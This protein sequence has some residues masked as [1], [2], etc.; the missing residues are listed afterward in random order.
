MMHTLK[1][2]SSASTFPV[3]SIRKR[4]FTLIELLVVIAIIAIL[5]G[6]LLPALSKA[7]L[8]AQA[9]QCLNSTKQLTLSWRMYG[10]DCQEKLPYAFG[11]GAQEPY[12]WISGIRLDLTSASY[13]WD[14]DITIK[15]S[16]LWT[17]CGQNLKIFQ[18]AADKIRVRNASGDMVQRVRSM[19]M[20]TFVGGNGDD[21]AAG[22]DPAG[23]WQRG[24]T[25]G[26]PFR[27][28]TKSTQMQNAAMTIVL[29][30]ERP[31]LL[32]D[33][34]FAINM[35]GFLNPNLTT[36][37][38][39]PGIQHDKAAGISFADGHSEVKKWRS[40]RV[41]APVASGGTDRNNPD[42]IWL[43]QRATIPQ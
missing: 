24:P 3:S 35:T 19:S 39:F 27:V 18:C 1:H 28:Y 23:T 14:P 7:K 22:N 15:K 42:V 17:Y 21:A 9:V 11:T 12:S 2:R 38:D 13:N 40:P 29:L 20:N 41:T 10:D 8:K 34:L 37:S 16:P 25:D 5:A 32:N 43:Q 6:L 33:G 30:D 26:G 36:V 4:G 31:D